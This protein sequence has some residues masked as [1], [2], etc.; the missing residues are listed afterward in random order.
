MVKVPLVADGQW[1][2]PVR[3]F[4]SSAQ[5]SPVVMAD[6]GQDPK[7]PKVPPVLGSVWETPQQFV[8]F[9]LLCCVS[10]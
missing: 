1:P 2:K 9:V 10:S 8:F 4:T 5:H 7:I 6:E 3:G